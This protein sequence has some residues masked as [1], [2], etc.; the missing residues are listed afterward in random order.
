MPGEEKGEFEI[1]PVR[2]GFTGEHAVE[3]LSGLHEG[4]AYV[5]AGAFELK[6]ETVTANLDAHAG[7]G[8]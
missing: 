8:H 2:T 7:H 6:A 4:D 5:A 3:I 1:L